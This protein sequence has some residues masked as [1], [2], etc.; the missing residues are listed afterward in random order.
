M[1][2]HVG[3]PNLP[4]YFAKMRRLLRPGGLMMNHSITAGGVENGEVGGG[5]GDFI[6][7]YIFPGGQLVHVSVIMDAMTRGNL[8]AVD[9]ECLRPHYARTLWHWADALDAH[10]DEARRILGEDAE[11]IIRAYRLYLAGSA[12]GFE[13]GWT[14]LFQ[15]VAS[16]PAE[17]ATIHD[18]SAGRLPWTRS[19]YPFNRAYIY[20]R[21]AAIDQVN[22]LEHANGGEQ[23]D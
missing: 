2:E 15:I 21:N 16:R 20:A 7:R 17:P 1:C 9:A 22:E 6:D 14:S 23:I 19:D 5:M 13:R 4:L 10:I 8:E 3:R 12:M 18:E 11:K